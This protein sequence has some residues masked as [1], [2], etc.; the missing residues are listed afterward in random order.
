MVEQNEHDPVSFS[1]TPTMPELVQSKAE[2]LIHS[3]HRTHGGAM[4]TR[5][6]GLSPGIAANPDWD[7][8][9]GSC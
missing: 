8:T 5:L 7:S 3:L 1:A 9:A 4:N 2:V 6:I